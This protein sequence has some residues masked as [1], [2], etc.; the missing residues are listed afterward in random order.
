MISY[1]LESLICRIYRNVN[2]AQVFFILK[3]R[4]FILQYKNVILYFYN[5]VI[6][7]VIV[8]SVLCKLFIVQV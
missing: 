4:F 7:F 6:F 3:F 1:E 8:K 5:F 2:R